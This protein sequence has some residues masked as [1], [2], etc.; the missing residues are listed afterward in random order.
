MMNSFKNKNIN[1]TGRE[2]EE[3][4]APPQAKR[5]KKW[6]EDDSDDDREARAGNIPGTQR[7]QTFTN[8]KKKNRA[9]NEHPQTLDEL[10]ALA[11]GLLAGPG[12]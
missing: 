1:I 2:E 8:K 6:F 12:S 11:S 10:E 3:E 4:E 5:A 7:G 9:H